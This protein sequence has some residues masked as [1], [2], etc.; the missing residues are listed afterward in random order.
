MPSFPNQAQGAAGAGAGTSQPPHV[1]AHAAGGS[2]LEASTPYETKGAAAT[3]NINP[4]PFLTATEGMKPSAQNGQMSGGL[5]AR[6]DGT[7]FGPADQPAAGVGP[8]MQSTAQSGTAAGA[9]R[10]RGGGGLSAPVKP[11]SNQ[12]TGK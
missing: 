2:N 6:R 7:M 1:D 10:T 8:G 5:V 9:R 11:P 4:A 12:S 3:Q